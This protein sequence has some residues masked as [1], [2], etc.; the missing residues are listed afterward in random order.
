MGGNAVMGSLKSIS[1][2]KIYRPLILFGIVAV[3]F[4][5]IYFV[6]DA[7]GKLASRT[8]DLTYSFIWMVIKGLLISL[9]FS[10]SH[11]KGWFTKGKLRV[12]YG[13]GMV[14]AFILLIVLA[15]FGVFGINI[16]Q[17]SFLEGII[18]IVIIVFEV[19]MVLFWFCLAKT[20]EKC[21]EKE[22]SDSF[23]M[24]I[25]QSVGI[26]LFV[27][28][29]Y[30]V[31]TVIEN[32]IAKDDVFNQNATASTLWQYG[33]ALILVMFFSFSHIKG[34]FTRGKFK[35]NWG[36]LA[37][38]VVLLIISN[39]YFV[40]STHF[41]I[42]KYNSWFAIVVAVFYLFQSVERIPAKAVKK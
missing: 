16:A 11:I 18:R 2:H 27:A 30:F 25:L 7:V 9:L 1:T 14:A 37:V 23:T 31:S 10:F 8:Y 35:I 24:T 22:K 4:I 28:A 17:G 36:T 3:L 21:P 12:Q 32:S 40:E 20:I 13:Y 33:K 5:L 34:W 42:L 15:G 41:Y 26:I 38:S 6:D 39:V 29:F 19:T